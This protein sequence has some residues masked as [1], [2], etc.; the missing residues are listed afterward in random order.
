M[1]DKNKKN[2]QTMKKSCEPNMGM[3]KKYYRSLR[4]FAVDK[5]SCV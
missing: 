2:F 4:D 5:A 3:E 1:Q